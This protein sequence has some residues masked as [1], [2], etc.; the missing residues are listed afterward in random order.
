[1][2]NTEEIRTDA[3]AEHNPF[4]AYYLSS[5]IPLLEREQAGM[6]GISIAFPG[7]LQQAFTLAYIIREKLPAVYLTAGGPAFTQLFAGLTPEAQERLRPPFHSIVLYE[8]EEA[9]LELVRGVESGRYPEGMIHGTQGLSVAELPAPDFYGLPLGKYLA[10]S[11]VLP[12]DTSRGCYW[13]RC[14]FCHYGLARQGTACYRERTPGQI[15]QDLSRL[16]T[17]YGTSLFY[18]SEDTLAPALA[19]KLAR[20]FIERKV[21]WQWS[22]D[23][24]PEAA[25][26]AETG[27]LLAE[28]GAISLA[29]GMESAAPRILKL[30]NKGVTVEQATT[31]ARN[32]ASAGI[33]VEGMYFLRFPTETTAEAL[34]T[35]TAIKNLYDVLALFIC[36]EFDLTAGSGLAARPEEFNI[37]ELWYVQ[38]DEFKTKLF[39]TT[40]STPPGEQALTRID[41]TLDNT[42]GRYWLHPYPWAGSLSTAHTLLWVKRYG[43]SVFKEVARKRPR[44]RVF[45][46]K[47]ITARSRFD[48][49]QLQELVTE[50]EAAI[51]H[52]MLYKKRYI[53]R[54]AYNALASRV[55]AVEP[56]SCH[57]RL[58]AGEE[59]QKLKRS[60]T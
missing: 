30:I 5:L 60:R 10:P 27:R 55:A 28:G 24:R 42:A 32:L 22:S 15:M 7:Q 41:D 47:T 3:Q 14:A 58:S 43:P 17:Q 23:I 49:Y 12:Y 2:L 1:M 57:W 21:D 16:S 51:W 45:G 20:V 11:L 8:G 53:S 54:A 25:L 34:T 39:Y 18:F 6:V 33:A 52:E 31:A 4:Y 36:G 35:L 9:L 40:G 50:N 46:Q 37:N 48:L 38:G 26:T 56:H 29:L 13:G 44:P 19:V 59:P